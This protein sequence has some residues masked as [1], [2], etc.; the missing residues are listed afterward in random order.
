[1][2]EHRIINQQEEHRFVEILE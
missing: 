1:M 2:V